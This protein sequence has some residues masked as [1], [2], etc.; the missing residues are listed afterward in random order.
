M[1]E[2]SAAAFHHLSHAFGMKFCK[3]RVREFHREQQ[4]PL[5]PEHKPAAGEE[6]C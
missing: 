3:S 2:K 6:V 4:D 1:G 5:R